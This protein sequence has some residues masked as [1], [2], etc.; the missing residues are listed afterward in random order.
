MFVQN[1]AVLRCELFLLI[2]SSSK[3]QENY[4]NNE[5]EGYNL[6]VR[7]EI[8]ANS[9]TIYSDEINPLR[10][11]LYERFTNNT[12]HKETEYE[13]SIFSTNIDRED[14]D[15]KLSKLRRRSAHN[16]ENDDKLMYTYINSTDV[17]HAENS[18]SLEVYDNLLE[19]NDSMSNTIF[20]NS[21]K[22]INESNTVSFQICHNIT[23][24]LFCCP[25]GNI[26][27]WNDSKCIPKKM[28]YVFPNV[29][30]YM[31]DL[32]QNE[33]KIVDEFFQLAV[34]DPCLG[35][36][37]VAY[38]GH[39]Y[40]YKIFANGSIYIPYYATLIESTSYCF[41][42]ILERGNTFEITFCSD[43]KEL[44]RNA[45]KYSPEFRWIHRMIDIHCSLNLVGILFL[46]AVFLVYS[47]LPE[48]RNEHGFM[49]RNYCACLSITFVIDT[50]KVLHLKEEPTYIRPVCITIA[51]LRYFWFMSSSFW[52]SIMSFNMWRTFREFS[53]LQRNVKGIIQSGKKKLVYYAIFAYG[54]PFVFA[55]VCVIV[56]DYLSEYLP[57]N[58]RPE[59][60]EGSCWYSSQHFEAYIFYYYWISTTC[61]VSSICLSISSSRNIKQCEKDANFRLTDSESRQY[62]QNKKWF[63][64]YMKFF[65]ILFITMGINWILYTV[66]WHLYTIQLYYYC[67]CINIANA[68]LNVTEY[69]LVFIIFVWKKKIKSMLLKRF[70]FETNTST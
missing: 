3:S 46:V 24:I 15:S 67:F 50:V 63:N 19:K 60:V 4:T 45:M 18:T 29:Y 39:Q 14:V 70:G 31:N 51:F 43:L 37:T 30:E 64:L 47:I 32:T 41:T 33:S 48:L 9:T 8:Y 22:G 12:Q 57:K 68:L 66:G 21:N 6:T 38:E 16:H 11:N 40:D 36:R 25:L 55:I 7:Y 17:D 5:D 58:L 44:Y 20:E 56:A 10:Y 2:T 27:R 65:I 61:I 69:F 35:S 28:E 49:L 42:I 62:N 26:M 1:F 23:C 34:Y 54:C 59:F 52:L 13:F 53:S